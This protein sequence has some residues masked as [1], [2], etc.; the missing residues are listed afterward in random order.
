MISVIIAVYKGD[1]H[2]QEQI[3]SILPQLSYEDEII[4]SDDRPGSITERI[5]KRLAASDSRI[6]WVEGKN[7]GSVANIVNG[8][9]HC[10]GDRIFF[11]GHKDVWLPDK[12]KRVNEAFDSGADMVLH[13]AYI[14]DELLN[15]TDYSFFEKVRVKKGSINNI[16]H[17]SYLLSC[18]AIKRQMLKK[19][20]PIPRSV[21]DVGQWI[22]IICSLCGKVKTVDIPLIYCRVKKSRRSAFFDSFTIASSERRQ[23]I[24]KLYK[25][26]IF[27]RR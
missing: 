11:C 18:V 22:G 3:S 12:I 27:E 23:L 1:K 14:T 7:K 26:M 19:I 20:M 10:K 9:R 6:I 16:H 24:K 8:L 4:V 25:R 5:V 13:N 21:P 17:N 2:L 15:I